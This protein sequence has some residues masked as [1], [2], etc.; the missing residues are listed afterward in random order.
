MTENRGGKER[1]INGGPATAN[2]VRDWWKELKHKCLQIESAI[3]NF[4][5]T[6][7]PKSLSPNIDAF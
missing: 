3:K 4:L 5:H 1:K 2:Q 7:S 6:T